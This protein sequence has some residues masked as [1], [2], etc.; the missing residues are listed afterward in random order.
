MQPEPEI[1]EAS[2]IP[3]TPEAPETP[4]VEEAAAEPVAVLPPVRDT[5]SLWLEI[6]AVCFVAVLPD[7]WSS[8]GLL[9]RSQPPDWTFNEREAYLI[10]RSVQVSWLVLYLM[11]RSG[12]P[13]SRFGLVA[14]RWIRDSLLAFATLVA[15]YFAYG[16]YAAGA[17]SLIPAETMSRETQRLNEL[18]S[19]P[20]E[21]EQTVLFVVSQLANG[22][23]EELVM[24]G[25]LIPRF[26]DL[27]GSTVKALLFSSVLFSS[28][29]LYQGLYGAGSALVM[30]L[31]FGVAFCAIRRIWPVAAAHALLNISSTLQ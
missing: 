9:F 14:P 26:E 16:F 6:V 27:F 21:P 13:W 4:G 12:T 24:R 10:F 17:M 15:A 1:P 19:G 5:R 28:Y 20:R 8:L 30:G 25:Y 7:L 2:E 29:H 23:A 22:F 18:F 31:V 3:E 11:A